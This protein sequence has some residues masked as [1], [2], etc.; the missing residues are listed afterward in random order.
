MV[1]LSGTVETGASQFSLVNGSI[2]IKG[3]GTREKLNLLPLPVDLSMRSTFDLIPSITN[4]NTKKMYEPYTSKKLNNDTEVGYLFKS[5]VNLND[6]V[7]NLTLQL[8]GEDALQNAI[9]LASDNISGTHWQQGRK[10]TDVFPVGYVGLQ[11]RLKN[12]CITAG[13]NTAG[14]NTAGYNN[15]RGIVLGIGRSW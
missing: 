1:T 6:S 8:G 5:G 4:F 13:Y 15:Q 11:Y 12:I 9:N 14:D 2:G 7:P 10:Q 3:E